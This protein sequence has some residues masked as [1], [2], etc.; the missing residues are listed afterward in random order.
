MLGRA[1]AVR[2]VSRHLIIHKRSNWTIFHW[3]WGG[4]LPKKKVLTSSK[5]H[6]MSQCC[7]FLSGTHW[8]SLQLNICYTVRKR[9]IIPLFLCSETTRTFY[10]L[11]DRLGQLDMYSCIVLDKC[12]KGSLQN[13]FSVKVGILSQ[14]AWPPP[15]P[16]RWDFFREFFGNFRQKRV[17]YAIKTVICKSWDWV[18]PP[19]PL[20]GPNSQLLPKICFACFPYQISSNLRTFCRILW[21]QAFREACKTN[22]R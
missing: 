18:R 21:W 3:I 4:F 22:F 13:K 15:L 12:D 9:E 6:H 5:N 10:H 19:P 17:K 11:P 1:F 20:L 16:E 14:P 8:L 7:T 2:P